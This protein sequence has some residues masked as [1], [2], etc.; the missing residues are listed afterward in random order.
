MQLLFPSIETSQKV[1][2]RSKKNEIYHLILPRIQKYVNVTHSTRTSLVVKDQHDIE[3]FITS[4]K[5]N[6]P[7]EYDFILLANKFSNQ[8]FLDK[9]IVLKEWLVHPKKRIYTSEEII[10]SWEGQFSF[11]KENPQMGLLG[12]RTPQIGAIYSTLG[13]LTNSK[14]IAT[15]VLPT[16]TGKTET[17]LSILVA[18]PCKK[19]LVTVPSDS[20]RSQLSSKFIDLGLLQMQDT[21]GDSILNPLAKCPIV[22]ILNTG[23]DNLTELSSFFEQC[24]V[25]VSTMNLVTS[26][27]LEQ[28]IKIAHLCSHLFVDEAHHSKAGNWDKF[29]KKFEKEKV[30]QFTATPYRNDGQSL[31]GKIIYNFTLKEAQDQGYFKKIDFIPI[32]EYEDSKI[33]QKIADAAIQKLREDISNGFD[34]ILMARCKDKT[35]AEEVFE[36]YK[37]HTDLNPI[38]IHSSVLG[39]NA[40]KK[41]IVE[42][43]HKIIVCVDMLGEGFDLPELKIA[44][45]HDIRKSLPITLQF[46]GR[47]T[48]TSRDSNLGHASFIA[49]LY[50]PEINDVLSLLFIKA[51]NWNSILPTLSQQAT[52]DELDLHNFLSGFNQMEKSLIPYQNISP[53]FSIVAYK[54]QT[55][56]WNPPNFKQGIK[57][58]ESYDHKFHDINSEEKTLI[59]ILGKKKNI[60]WVN[61]NDITNTDWNIFIVYWEQTKNTL[62]IHSSEKGSVHT[63]LAKAIIGDNAILIKDADV[64]RAF[65]EIDRIKL[66]NVGLRKGLG[67]NITFQSYY[68]KGVQEALSLTEEKT[69]VNNNVFGIGFEKG[70]VTSIGCSRKGRIWSYSRGSIKQFI[71]WCNSIS[72]KLS[73][74]SING[75]ELLL[76][77]TIKPQKIQERPQL[78]PLTV[79]WNPYCYKESENRISFIIRD[80]KYNLSN[81]ELNISN[82]STSGDLTFTF[83]TLSNA[84]VSFKLEL[85]TNTTTNINSSDYKI[86]KTSTHPLFVRI[87]SQP[88]I[89]IESFF[90][91]H[92]PIFW[93]ADGSYL[94]GNDYIKFQEQ[95]L[96][97]PQEKLIAWN[98]NGV[99]LNEES[100]RFDTLKTSS[101]QYHCI[102]KFRS[103]SHDYD[104]VFND[105]GSGEIA[106]IVTIK[107]LENEI[108]VEFYHLKF[109]ANGRVSKQ[110]ANFYEVCGQAQKSLIWKYKEGRDFIERLIR[111]EHTKVGLNQTRIRKG[112]MTDLE[113]L[114]TVVKRTKPVKYDIY[115]VQPGLSKEDVSPEILTLLGVTANHIKK[116]G[117]I[118]LK[119][120]VNE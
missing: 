97:Y 112:T 41:D 2:N 108:K 22:G 48:R 33:D 40:L 90:N 21:N 8:D 53:A 66:Y 49:N 17:M 57:G 98:W 106:D 104:I 31:D 73:N 23:F 116:Q 92:P 51:S 68:G 35:R 77:H 86:T 43:K 78:Y 82:P 114:L 59:V 6:L 80:K 100:E 37:K 42:K 24:N 91:K 96:L 115:I 9:N 10:N 1:G 107:N 120:I 72:L 15:V 81:V 63:E 110:I 99:S 88:E 111:R 32:R 38:V 94:Q 12:L 34:H 61:S 45:F 47:F 67:K 109:A 16:G 64:F 62:F 65:Y 18:N 58:Y 7:S 55:Q 27:S 69:G 56:I 93:F 79:D 83:D 52:E 50:Q 85:I 11:K 113:N 30:V 39:K 70:N 44:A 13:H 84:Q 117:G 71:D 5:N 76:K 118:D 75:D 95:I 19:L 103:P 46:A 28:Q 119:I 14:E 102:E 87:G 74:N 54:N 20:L 4:N 29:I 60:D 89:E 105:D 101:I 3:Y 25:V 26:C 36:I